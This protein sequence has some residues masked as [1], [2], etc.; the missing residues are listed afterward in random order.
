[1]PDSRTRRDIKV[2]CLQH[3][4]RRLN[5]IQPR[6]RP[7]PHF[8]ADRVFPED[9][10]DRLLTELPATSLYT[11]GSEGSKHHGN[12]A[13]LY[14]RSETMDRFPE[15]SRELWYGVRSALAAPELKRAVFAC[16][17]VGLAHRFHID[18]K[19]AADISGY[20]RALLYQETGGYSIAPHTDTRRKLATVQF[21]LTDD[22]SQED[23]G[24]SLYR[25]SA[26]PFHLLQQPRGFR[27]VDRHPFA[28]NSVLAFCVVNTMRMRSWHGRGQLRED[29]GVRNTLLQIYYADPADANPE[30]VRE[31]HAPH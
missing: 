13:D 8:W 10:H 27:E 5:E 4:V 17:S 1:M 23:L 9:I 3:I 30:M 21:A 19:E 31:F 7:F 2:A 16:L 22:P 15:C 28:R 14:L 25:L 29:C 24:T 20:P 26:N 18:E 6:L 11:H 12:R